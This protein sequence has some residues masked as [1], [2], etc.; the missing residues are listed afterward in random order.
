MTFAERL[1]YLREKANMT[2]KEIAEKIGLTPQSY[3]NYEKRNY[4]P[5]PDL[6][7]KM[8]TALGVTPNDLLG[9]EKQKLNELEYARQMLGKFNNL[10]FTD[11]G[12][13]V[14]YRVLTDYQSDSDIGVTNETIIEI[15]K[16]KFIE[17]VNQSRLMTEDNM[18]S[19]KERF[20]KYDFIRYLNSLCYIY[21]NID[22]N[23]K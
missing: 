18:N 14:L 9:Y 12:N 13:T 20:L 1:K 15:P 7:V 3:N 19:Y 5:T 22:I 11:D 16:D 8:A 10:A 21:H 23:K 6:L 4:N 17:F 2:Q